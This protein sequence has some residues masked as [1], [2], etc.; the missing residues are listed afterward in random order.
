MGPQELQLI[1]AQ[2]WRGNTPIMVCAYNGKGHEKIIKY[3]IERGAEM[4]IPDK[5]NQNLLHILCREAF[6]MGL[7]KRFCEANPELINSQ[8]KN[9]MTPIMECAYYAKSGD[10]EDK[11]AR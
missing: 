9:G 8:N 11:E 3:L 2:N 10:K 5:N 1:N 7:I 4:N 6:G